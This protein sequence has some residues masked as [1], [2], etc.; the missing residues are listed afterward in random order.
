[1]TQSTELQGATQR[2]RNI[3]TCDLI[4]LA[5]CTPRFTRGAYEDIDPEPM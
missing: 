2:I 5:A 3:G 4:F 1:M